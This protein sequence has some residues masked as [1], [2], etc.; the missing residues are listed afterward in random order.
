MGRRF[1]GGARAIG[2]S[3]SDG[4]DPSA[5][6]IGREAHHDPSVFVEVR[7]NR[8]GVFNSPIHPSVQRGAHL[9]DRRVPRALGCGLGVKTGRYQ[10]EQ[11]G[12]VSHNRHTAETRET[13]VTSL[14]SW[15]FLR[16]YR[17]THGRIG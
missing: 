2:K 10:E 12:Q 8:S 11:Y 6:G 15:R 17:L 4:R 1:F 9:A 3:A 16:A 13:E 14:S 7:R 5:R